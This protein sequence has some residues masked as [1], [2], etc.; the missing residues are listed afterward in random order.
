MRDNADTGILITSTANSGALLSDDVV[1]GNGIRGIALS[2]AGDTISSSTVYGNGTSNDGYAGIEAY[3]SDSLVTG[4]V[5]FSNVYTGIDSQGTVTDSTAFGN[6]QNEIEM[7]GGTVMGSLVY[8]ETSSNGGRGGLVLERAS[9]GEDNVATLNVDGIFVEVGSTATNNRS[10]ANSDAGITVGSTPSYVT[11]VLRG[12]TIYGNGQG[13]DGS[14]YANSG[15]VSGSAVI[16]NNLIYQ[17]TTAGIDFESGTNV[18]YEN[19]TIQQA[20]GPAIAVTQYGNNEDIEN[21]IFLVSGSPAV[22]VDATSESNAFSNYNLF[23]LTAGGTVGSFGGLGY[24]TLAAWSYELGFDQSSTLGDPGLIDPAGPDGVAG[25]APVTGATP[26]VID[27]TD[28]GFT[29]TGA[30]TTRADGVG[31]SAVVIAAGSSATASWT[32]TGLVAGESYQ[33]AATWPGSSQNAYGDGDY[34]VAD[35]QGHILAGNVFNQANPPSS[36]KVALPDNYAEIGSFIATGSTVT[37]TLSGMPDTA[38]IADA[39]S[40]T[41]LGTDHGADDD[42]QIAAG[43]QAVDAGDPATPALLEPAPDGGRVNQGYQGATAASLPN[44]SDPEVQVLSPAGLAKLQ[45][46]QQATIDFRTYDVAAEQPVLLDHPVARRSR[47]RN[48]ATGKATP[49][50]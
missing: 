47:R 21:N 7:Y 36:S 9:L 25:Y 35:A 6:G 45:L 14:L 30:T 29:V 24:A 11:A 3:S 16:D 22:T 38:V 50:G 8:G 1:Y 44:P 40:L 41:P 43:S 28:A 23:D 17:N 48:R 27:S 12:N 19:N 34:V 39:V 49:T 42:F 20:G 46:G 33:L 10:D 4:S 26:T 32:F 2:G 31:G 15:T 18:A 5:V 37:V 13:I